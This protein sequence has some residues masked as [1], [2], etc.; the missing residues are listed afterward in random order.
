MSG[1]VAELPLE[2]VA[3]M[4]LEEEDPEG[5]SPTETTTLTPE[6]T[7]TIGTTTTTATTNTMTTT[8]ER[9]IIKLEV[10]RGSSDWGSWIYMCYFK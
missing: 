9:E 3:T 8:G 7:T 10:L 4:A 6:K 1:A 2:E 5:N